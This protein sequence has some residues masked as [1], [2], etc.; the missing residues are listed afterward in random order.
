[1]VSTHYLFFV[2]GE[3][4]IVKLTKEDETCKQANYLRLSI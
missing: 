3:I 1:V 4:N 2:N